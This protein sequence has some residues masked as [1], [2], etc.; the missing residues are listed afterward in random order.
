MDG[1]QIVLSLLLAD[2]AFTA[3]VAEDNIVAGVLPA[4]SALPAVSVTRVSAVDRNIPSPGTMRH[5]AERVQVTA[6]AASYPAMKDVIA[7]VRAAAA[8][9]VGEAADTPGVT[10]HTDSAG[11]D[12]M[13]DESSIHLG[14]QDFIVTFSEPR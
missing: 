11:P 12:F 4:G 6:L 7:A 9:F 8:D 14:S 13:D 5:V 3:I 2:P 10:V 1:V